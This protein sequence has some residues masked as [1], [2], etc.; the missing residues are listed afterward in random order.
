MKQVRFEENEVP[1]QTLERFGLTQPMI[2]DLPLWALED[3]GQGRRSPV[4][5]IKVT[6]EAGEILA[7]RTRFALVRMDDNKVDVM[8]FPVLERS[9]LEQFSKEEQ[10]DLQAGKAILADVTDKDGRK[11]KAFVQIDPETNHVM[12]VSTPVIGRNLEVLKNELGLSSAELKVMQRGEPLTLIME[13]EQITVGID[14]NTKSGLRL[15]TGD[16]QKWKENAKREW[17]KYTFGCY[18]CWIMGDDGNLDYV[19][20]EEYSEELWNE[21]KKSGER[22][23]AAIGMRK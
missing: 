2:E 9:P 19:P 6:N 20:E 3:I 11:N 18:G 23:R 13:D 7:S 5:P 15:Q 4:L 17:D 8:F 1:Y 12:S 21:Q 14:L 22:N 10:E 16:S